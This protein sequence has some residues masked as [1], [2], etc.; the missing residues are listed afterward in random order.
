LFNY[1][2]KET[3]VCPFLG[4]LAPNAVSRPLRVIS[5]EVS[6]LEDG[7]TAGFGNVTLKKKLKNGQIPPP[8]NRRICQ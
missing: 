8:Q 1:L 2:K 7:I 3:D 5:L 6:L 4:K